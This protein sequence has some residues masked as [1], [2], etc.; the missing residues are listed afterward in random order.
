LVLFRL[1]QEYLAFYKSD[2]KKR[3]FH[4]MSGKP[5]HIIQYKPQ[6]MFELKKGLRKNCEAPANETP[7]K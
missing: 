7:V 4:Q 3:N 6:K 2:A 5:E 1:G